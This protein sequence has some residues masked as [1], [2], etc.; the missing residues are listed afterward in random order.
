MENKLVVFQDK[1]IRRTLHNGEWWFSVS[2]VVE[3][4]TNTPNAADYIKKMRNRDS[5][6]AQGWGQIVT[7]LWLETA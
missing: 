5:E 4:L 3:E 6:L 7:P 1:Q 2:D